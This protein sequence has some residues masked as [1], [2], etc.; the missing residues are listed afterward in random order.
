MYDFTLNAM[1]DVQPTSQIVEW[2]SVGLRLSSSQKLKAV[3]NQWAHQA[4]V[5][6]KKFKEV[7]DVLDWF[8]GV[9]F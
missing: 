3:R 2:P 6:Q 9:T 8:K 5:D 7:I 1:W 4:D